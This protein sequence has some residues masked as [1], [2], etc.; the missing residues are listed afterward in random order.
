[1]AVKRL[2]LLAMLI[3]CSARGA[4][5]G[6]IPASLALPAGTSVR[7]NAGN[8]GFESFTPGS[9]GGA[10]DSVFG[11]TGVVTAQTGDYTVAEV[12]GAVPNTLTLT[13]GASSALDLSTNRSFSLDT[14]S[15]VSSNGFLK[16]TSA[17]TW[18]NDSSTYITGNQTIT[19]SGDVTGS[20][21]TA[22]TTTQSKHVTLWA[23]GAGIVL[24][25]GTKVPQKIVGGGTLS[26]WDASCTPS[27]S[28]T[29][30][31]LRSANGGGL[32]V[33]SLVGSGTK[34]AISSNTEASGTITD[35][36]GS[37]TLT[38]KDNLAISLSGIT[39]AT[40]VNIVFNYK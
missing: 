37:T 18:T 25:I 13:I 6:D 28:I 8:S 34:P 11:R 36:T 14:I 19:L 24:G 32:P 5:F 29:I 1:M 35:W 17:N 31:L 15:G 7:R 12:T 26:S 2:F 10:V 21:T 23:N 16:R 39:A 38:D 4:D 33:T 3:A 27:C 9:G 30:D 40:Y 22:I 20:G